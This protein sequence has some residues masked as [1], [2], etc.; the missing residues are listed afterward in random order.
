MSF[1]AFSDCR[2]NICIAIHILC[3]VPAH[4]YIFLCARNRT[5]PVPFPGTLLT[6]RPK[7]LAG[8]YGIDEVN[9]GTR[10]RGT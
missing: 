4:V 8:G 3:S 6:C 1:E 7:L 5:F 2:R 9:H 10:P